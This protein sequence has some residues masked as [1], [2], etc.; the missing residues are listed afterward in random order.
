MALSHNDEDISNSPVAVLTYFW[1]QAGKPPTYD[2]EQWIQLF[3]VAIL[4]RHSIS[5][6]ELI[7]EEVANNPILG[8]QH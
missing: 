2:W 6:Y 5:I 4:A 3:E 7:R 8:M 1:Q